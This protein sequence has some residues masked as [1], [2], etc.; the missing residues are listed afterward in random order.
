MSGS[1]PLDHAPMGAGLPSPGPLS[2]RDRWR[3]LRNRLFSSP[4]F[5]RWAAAFPLT[6]PM[7]RR[8][9]RALFDIV[10][11]FTYSQVLFACVRL[12]LFEHLARGPETATAL[13]HRLAMPEDNALRLLHAAASLR[14]LERHDDGRWGLGPLGAPM[15]ALPAVAAMVEHHAAL[16]QDL[17]DPVA[18]LRGERPATALSGYWPYAD[19]DPGARPE[20]LALDKV[21][22]YSTLM[23]AS[24]PLVSE[25]VLDA[26]PLRGHRRLLDV[27]GGEGT[28]LAA[29]AERAPHLELMLFDL[30]AVAERAR[31][32]LAERG[33]ASRVR[34]HGGSF[35]TD[36][37]PTGADI[38][39]L[40]RVLFDH[41]D[42]RVLTILRAARAALPPEGVLLVSEPMSGTPGAQAI[43][44]AYY[45]LYLLAM[46]RGR[47]RTPERIREL[48]LAAGFAE[49]RLLPTR[50]PLQTR[51]MLARG[52]SR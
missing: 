15:V 27:G 17:A 8:E 39:T 38:I 48:L 40:V 50:L 12:R 47:S 28:F 36:P 3:A 34:T 41:P 9:S 31:E 18:L 43:G 33:L 10:A 42:E 13:A 37:L 1:P 5:H 2:L 49:A 6:R 26:Y 24:Q 4:R 29:V 23:S 52:R 16:Y 46:G 25:Q 11:G 7:A 30:P 32:R 22:E 35:F 44:D 51:V 14:L 45:G 19:T 21:A 20:A